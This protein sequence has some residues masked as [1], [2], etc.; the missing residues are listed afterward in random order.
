MATDFTSTATNRLAF[1]RWFGGTD[2]GTLF[3]FGTVSQFER[4][5]A[6]LRAGETFAPVGADLDGDPTTA[7]DLEQLL[8]AGRVTFGEFPV[9]VETGTG[10][11]FDFTEEG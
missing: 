7:E 9:T 11:L 5:T 10:E 3:E 8:V 4:V 6:A 2:R 1:A